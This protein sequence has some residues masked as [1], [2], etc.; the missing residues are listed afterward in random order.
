VNVTYCLSRQTSTLQGSV[1]SFSRDGFGISPGVTDEIHG[2]V[3]YCEGRAPDGITV[4]SEFGN[5]ARFHGKSF[6]LEIALEPLAQTFDPLVK[7]VETRGPVIVFRKDPAVTSRNHSKVEARSSGCFGTG[8]AA[9]KDHFYRCSAGP[10]SGN[11]KGAVDDTMGSI[12]SY[13]LPSSQDSPLASNTKG[14]VIGQIRHSLTV[15]KAKIPPCSVCLYEG[16]VKL[17]PKNEFQYRPGEMVHVPPNLPV[18]E[19]KFCRFCAH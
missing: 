9:V 14:T 10:G 13:E 15:E 19:L 7:G 3:G 4:R 8:L 18:I 6:C 16:A 12:R 17:R 1:D 2:T 5:S 11:A